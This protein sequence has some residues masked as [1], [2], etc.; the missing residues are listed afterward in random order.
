MTW[1]EAAGPAISVHLFSAKARG[2][3]RASS[4]CPIFEVGV[5]PESP[6]AA[7]DHDDRQ[8]VIVLRYLIER[9][10]SLTKQSSAWRVHSFQPDKRYPSSPVLHFDLRLSVERSADT[11]Y[12]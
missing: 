1:L 12:S 3:S 10:L 4:V 7:P 2:P 11:D 5:Y 6:S 9:A 8:H